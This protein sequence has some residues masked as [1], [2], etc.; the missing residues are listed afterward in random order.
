M[1]RTESEFLSIHTFCGFRAF[2][3]LPAYYPTGI[4]RGIRPFVDLL[5]TRAVERRKP[6]LAAGR[7]CLISL[8][9]FG[10]GGRI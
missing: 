6:R 7:M 8:L 9:D 3:S 2:L 4:A 5:L 10:C 1:T